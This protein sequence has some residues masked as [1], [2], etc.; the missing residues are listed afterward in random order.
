MCSD[1]RQPPFVKGIQE[2]GPVMLLNMIRDLAIPLPLR[3]AL[4]AHDTFLIAA[5]LQSTSSSMFYQV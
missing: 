3:E 4:V 2:T 5:H 1:G